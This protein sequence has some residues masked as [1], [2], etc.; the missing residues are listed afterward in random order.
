MTQFVVIDDVSGDVD[1][2]KT[3][4]KLEGLRSEE[5]SIL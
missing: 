4:L 3:Q 5:V 2:T 1:E